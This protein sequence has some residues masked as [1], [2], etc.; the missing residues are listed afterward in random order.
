M[1]ALYFGGRP[2]FHISYFPVPFPSEVSVWCAD[3]ATTWIDLLAA[4]S[5]YGPFSERLVGPS[6]SGRLHSLQR[7]WN[8]P[9]PFNIWELTC[10]LVAITV[11]L[12]SCLYQRHKTE[13]TTR[14]LFE[15]LPG[16]T[17][18]TFF[19]KD[20]PTSTVRLMLRNWVNGFTN[21]TEVIY[22]GWERK[23]CAFQDTIHLWYLSHVFLGIYEK[24]TNEFKYDGARTANIVKSWLSKN[25]P[26]DDNGSFRFMR[27]MG[28]VRFQNMDYEP[29]QEDC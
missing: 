1:Q 5:Q 20:I 18:I 7:E 16:P 11:E 4:D 21:C 26:K 14:Y 28:N 9:L 12:E 17:Q 13:T 29:C 10:L 3:N 2:A 19:G 22:D 6:A 25:L 15:R 23:G 27:D 24:P 8:A